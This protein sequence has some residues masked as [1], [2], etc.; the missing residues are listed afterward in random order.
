MV[1][2]KCFNCNKKIAFES[3]GKRIRCAYCGC[4]ML[5]KQRTEPTKVKAR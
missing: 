2:Y 3:I 4:K 5:F 1:K